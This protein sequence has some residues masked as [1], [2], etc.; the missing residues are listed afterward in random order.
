MCKRFGVSR[1]G[2]YA[3]RSRQP[4]AFA[5]GDKR[6]TEEQIRQAHM[7]G[8]GYYGSPRVTQYLRHRGIDVGRRRVARL[9]RKARLQGHG[10]GLFRSKARLPRRL[11]RR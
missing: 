4:S 2:F 11:Q 5:Q 9:M 10:N 1:S 3:S 6:L 7:A 8:Q